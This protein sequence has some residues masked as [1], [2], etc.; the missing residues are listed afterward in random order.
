MLH[1][2]NGT[3]NENNIWDFSIKLEIVHVH[4]TVEE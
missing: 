4:H 3:I 2:L 1:C